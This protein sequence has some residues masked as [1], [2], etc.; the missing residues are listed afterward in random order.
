MAAVLH[1]I[2]TRL[3]AAIIA[4]QLDHA[5]SKLVIVDG[6]HAAVRADRLGAGGQGAQVHRVLR[7]ERVGPGQDDRRQRPDALQVERQVGGRVI[8]ARGSPDATPRWSD[9][10]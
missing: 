1:S 8:G 9:F 7:D 4:F 6:Q 2:N 5:M 10:K 3:D